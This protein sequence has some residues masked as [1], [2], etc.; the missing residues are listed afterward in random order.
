MA[1]AAAFRG[2]SGTGS[3]HL[4]GHFADHPLQAPEPHSNIEERLTPF[5][6]LS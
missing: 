4:R 3:P 5:P 1:K 6:D 2:Q